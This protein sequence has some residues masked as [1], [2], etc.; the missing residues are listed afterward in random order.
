MAMMKCWT[1]GLTTSQTECRLAL[2]VLMFM[3]FSCVTR[4]GRASARRALMVGLMF[5]DRCV[6]STQLWH[7][8]CGWT[9][10]EV[11]QTYACAEQMGPHRHHCRKHEG[12]SLAH[13][14]STFT[15]LCQQ[16]LQQ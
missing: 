10:P 11:Q 13:L 4:G 1:N 14:G 8:T 15:K 3:P 5:G 2:V 16:Q 6:V 7:S 12:L 9:M